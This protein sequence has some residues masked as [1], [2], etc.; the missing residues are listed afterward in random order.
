MIWYV[1]FKDWLRILYLFQKVGVTV[2]NITRCMLLS[3][4]TI[5]EYNAGKNSLV[6]CYIKGNINP[7]YQIFTH[8]ICRSCIT[9]F[10][11]SLFD[12]SRNSALLLRILC[13]QRGRGIL[14][15]MDN[16]NTTHLWKIIHSDP[17]FLLFKPKKLQIQ[18]FPTQRLLKK[19]FLLHEE[20]TNWNLRVVSSVWTEYISIIWKWMC[21]CCET[22]WKIH[23]CN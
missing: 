14:S 9:I 8:L 11:I 5:K 21:L 12:I 1:H 13:G 16:R 3:F 23:R 4:A 15:I 18:T 22:F 6:C 19:E 7:P 2:L 10:P 17:Y 20:G